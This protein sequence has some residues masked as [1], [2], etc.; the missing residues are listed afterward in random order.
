MSLQGAT[1]HSPRCWET[2]QT[3]RET[4]EN[5][6]APV[7]PE[8]QALSSEL[9]PWQE[10]AAHTSALSRASPSP[11][12][13]SLDQENCSNELKGAPDVC[14]Q[15]AAPFSKL[16]W[17][18]GTTQPAHF[19][20]REKEQQRLKRSSRSPVLGLGFCFSTPGPPCRPTQR[21]G[22]G[23]HLK[24]TEPGTISKQDPQ[25]MPMHVK[26]WKALFNSPNPAKQIW[27]PIPTASLSS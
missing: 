25:K 5:R 23:P 4:A 12:S 20:H 13:D 27:V 24:P 3:Q 10:E 7:H 11:S 9:S 2:S 8:A 6:A 16:G 17:A 1:G 18:L 14:S 22:V 15:G 19:T 21:R 26:V